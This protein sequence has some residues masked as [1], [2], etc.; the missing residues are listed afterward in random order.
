MDVDEWSLDGDDAN[1]SSLQEGA[2]GND[3]E[4]SNGRL[5]RSP[6]DD[7]VNQNDEGGGDHDTQTESDISDSDSIEDYDPEV[8]EPRDTAWIE[9]ICA[10]GCYEN[11]PGA[12]KSFLGQGR[13]MHGWLRLVPG[14]GAFRD[15]NFPDVESIQMPCYSPYDEWRDWC[16]SETDFCYPV[17]R[18]CLELFC[19]YATGRADFINNPKLDQD[20]LYFALRDL[21]EGP[22]TKLSID[23]GKAK[24]CQDRFW[25]SLR[26]YEF[27]VA[28]PGVPSNFDIDN[29]VTT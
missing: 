29:P 23:Y 20:A 25:A 15:P 27:L 11:G 16:D 26:G 2:E 19:L 9:T 10:L 17:H 12:T 6:D 1:H 28:D 4:R 3:E 18:P 24:G 5:S 13:F 8:I 14:P 7:E 21:S 22:P